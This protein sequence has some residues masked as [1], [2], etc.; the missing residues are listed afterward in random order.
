MSPACVQP[1]ARPFSPTASRQP[2][3]SWSP[4]W[5]RTA[6]LFT[7]C[8]TR[9]NSGQGPT[10][11]T[12]SLAAPS[13]P[14]TPRA[15]PLAPQAARQSPWPQAP[16]G[17][18]RVP[19]S[20]DPCETPPASAA[21]SAC[22]PRPAVSPPAWPARSIQPSA[23]KAPWPAMSKT[24]RFSSTPWWAKNPPIPFRFHRTAPLT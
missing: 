6:R 10:P 21:S 8:R 23:S 11:S 24:W 16:H 22:G 14:G 17:W 15:P 4:I 9:R 2:P 13:I 20:A 18:L 7:P 12:K 5:R 19:I 1:K 3:M